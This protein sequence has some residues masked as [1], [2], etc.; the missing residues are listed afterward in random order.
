MIAG[1][2][3]HMLGG[4]GE[5]TAHV[6]AEQ[7]PTSR[8]DAGPAPAGCQEASHAEDGSAELAK[9]LTLLLP[10]E[11]GQ[12]AG[13]NAAS[14][15]DAPLTPPAVAE[16]PPASTQRL[17]TLKATESPDAHATRTEL[18]AQLRSF[19]ERCC[20]AGE[21]AEE[22]Y[23]SAPAARC[24]LK[25]QPGTR[26]PL[27]A[28]CSMAEALFTRMGSTPVA[29]ELLQGLVCPLIKVRVALSIAEHSAHVAMLHTEERWCAVQDIAHD[30]VIAADGFTYERAAME[31]W[32][33]HSSLS[34]VTGKR[35]RSMRL[36]P[37]A[38]FRGFVSSL[39]NSSRF[40]SVA[41]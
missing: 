31:E 5:G 39:V 12:S 26:S 10:S 9:L 38:L 2:A 22:W 19:V 17:P 40:V 15:A 27:F 21:G 41:S 8:S 16:A 37:N 29:A 7:T 13:S 24:L 25:E 14:A 28:P 34:P 6:E 11:R 36:Y 20:A 4:A 18:R 23:C 35:M 30:A 32:T 1:D 3:A 33:R